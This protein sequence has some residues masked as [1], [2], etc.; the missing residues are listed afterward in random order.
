MK[1]DEELEYELDGD[2]LDEGGTSGYQIKLAQFEGP[3]DLLLHLIKRAKI[4]ICEIYVSEITKQ[5]LEYIEELNNVDLEK[6]SEFLAMAAYLVE[7]KAKALLP[8]PEVYTEQ[9]EDDGSELIRRLEE[10]DLY[11]KAGEK[12]KQTETVKIHFR[13]PD[14]TVGDE[15]IALKDM[16]LDGLFGALQKIFARME[17]RSLTITEREI[18]RDAFTV[19]E[20]ITLIEY[21]LAEKHSVKFDE[22][23]EKDCTKSEIITTFQALL[24]L[25]KLQYLDAVQNETFG[26]ITLI[27]RNDDN[28]N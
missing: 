3:L 10:Y 4:Q 17:K 22:L 13:P 21:V 18:A 15:R 5:Y 8:K 16:N 2:S 28:G 19:A 23:F 6:A 11:K 12:M 24:E 25:M 14:P 27:K 9:D 7:I 26:E 20:K 1:N